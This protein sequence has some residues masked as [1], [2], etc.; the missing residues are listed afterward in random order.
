MTHWQRSVLTRPWVQ[1]QQN[2]C[3]L[4][5]VGQIGRVM[6]IGATV[7]TRVADHRHDTSSDNLQTISG[8][9]SAAASAEWHI[10]HHIESSCCRFWTGT[11]RWSIRQW[12]WWC[13]TRQ[14]KC[15]NDQIMQGSDRSVKTVICHY[16]PLAS[17]S[18]VAD[19]Q[20]H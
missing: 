11:A 7:A 5:S 17:L 9:W 1:I 3:V 10:I 6:A 13:N 2:V 4:G 14:K 15:R 12:R 20:N 16:L 19:S 18:F 8:Q